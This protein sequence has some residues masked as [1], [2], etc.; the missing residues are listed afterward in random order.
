[1]APIKS[2]LIRADASPE[3]GYGHIMRCLSLAN[4]LLQNNK[5]KVTFAT[6]EQ[7]VKAVPLLNKFPIIT[8][9]PKHLFNPNYLQECIKEESFDL[10]V[11]DSY[12]SNDAYE[13][14]LYKA[15]KYFLVLDDHP[16]R[17][18]QCHGLLDQTLN[19]NKQEY[20]SL[21]PFKC[22][23]FVGSEYTI[24][25]QEFTESREAAYKKRALI[26]EQTQ[27]NILIHLGSIDPDNIT[28]LALKALEKIR[29]I[30]KVDIVLT[31]MSPH[32]NKV[33]AY[34]ADTLLQCELH[35]DSQE[36]AKLMLNAD[37]CIGASGTTSWERCTLG[38]P[39]IVIV[40]ADNQ[41]DIALALE[42]AGGASYIGQAD[43]INIKQLYN[44]LSE[45]LNAK[46]LSVMSE[47]AFSVCD[48]KG[49]TQLLNEL[50]QSPF[51]N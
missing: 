13:A 8:L 31:S 20:Q 22:D 7:S 32:L 33:R 25:R 23:Y 19:R 9:P 29:N 38:L 50:K 14:F 41:K 46:T 2:A 5:T 47:K 36:V 40:Y 43:T 26:K 12:D 24:L 44:K 48:G 17:P 30:G 39:S 35:V 45:I 10:I 4:F 16:L 18:H 3:R 37:C 28:L 49:L 6:S 11:Q 51:L 1:M 27:F 15:A 42:Q 34:L 21:T